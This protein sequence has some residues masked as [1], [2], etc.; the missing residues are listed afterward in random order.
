MDLETWVVIFADYLI[1]LFCLNP[2][3]LTSVSWGLLL[4]KLFNIQI[5]VSRSQPRDLSKVTE[6]N[7]VVN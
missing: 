5:F 1:S 6:E 2:F 3:S 7:Q 4:N